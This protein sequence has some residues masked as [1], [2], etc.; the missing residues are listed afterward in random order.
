MLTKFTSASLVAAMLYLT[1]CTPAPK[2]ESA[3]ETLGEDW[4]AD[5]TA[6][7]VGEPDEDGFVWQTD[8]FAD[9]KIIRY[10][11]PGWEKLTAKQK[12]YVYYLKQAG[13]AGR[14]IIYDQNYRHNLAIRSALENIYENF[15]GDK[16]TV[17]WNRFETYLKRVWFSNGIHHHYSNAKMIPEF[18]KEYFQELMS[19]TDTEVSDELMAAIFDPNVDAKKVEQDPEKGL[20]EGSAVNF[21]GPNVTTEEA[22]AY[23]ESITTK[24]DKTPVSTGLNSRLVKN[25]AGEVVEEVYRIGGLYSDALTE[26]V[27]WL[28]KAEGVAENDKQASAL[29]KLIKYYETGDLKMWDIYNI[30]WVN[31]TEGDIDYI[32]G[33]VE[34][35]N[36]PLGYTGSFENIVQIKDFEASARMQVMMDNIQWFEDNSPTMEEHKK[37]SVVGITYNVVN[38]AGEAG[39][40]SPSTPIGVNL[41]NANWIRATHGSK[42]VSLGNI[43]EAYDKASG[44]GMIDEF[45]FDEE[46][47][48]RAKEYGSLAGSMHTALHEVVGH[49]SGKLEDG[50]GTPKETIKSYASAIEEARADLVALNFI[51]DPKMVELGLMETLDV[52]KAEYDGY[53]RNGMMT[54]LRRLKL[55]DNIEQ[56][57]MRNRSM[58]AHW[59]Y[60]RGKD[61]NV[62]EKI[63][64]DG[65]TYFKVRDYEK[66][67]ALF[68]EL[69]REVQRIKSQGD[70]EAAKNLIE[71]YGVQVD[72]ALHK[73]VLDRAEALGSAPYGGF[74]NPRLVPVTAEDGTI[75]DVK[76][77]YPDDF[78]EQMM[79]YSKAYSHLTK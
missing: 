33:F 7:Y 59:V 16:G 54:Q 35:Y 40:A 9:L 23:F 11:I 78:V 21:Y 65:K 45:A 13:L 79:Y 72:Q 77:E 52:G 44:P 47:A 74:I 15:D 39:D 34:V 62:I 76:V 2:T 50:V 58:V 4:Q 14:D 46:E 60:E 26:I 36:D 5:T 30:A 66:L 51:M 69:L 75:T 43:L 71:D 27:G 57:H 61:E 28:K 20:V 32:N 68:G 67:H 38:V 6:A 53:I 12:A 29:R 73:E 70:Y 17:G 8:Q 24:G 49:A 64:R 25:D 42:S 3:E 10:Q 48:N 19:A 1:S 55:G 22:E 37:K 63:V 18:S 41:P 56:T 31:A